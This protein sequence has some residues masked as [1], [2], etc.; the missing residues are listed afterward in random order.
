MVRAGARTVALW[1]AG[2]LA[3]GVAAD[4]GRVAA[5]H[6]LPAER[7]VV[8]VA[9]GAGHHTDAVLVGVETGTGERAAVDGAV[10]DQPAMVVVKRRQVKR[11]GGLSD[12]LV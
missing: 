7:A 5:L 11:E 12:H 6:A 1:A 8:L 3:S 4:A 10:A 9:A 2:E